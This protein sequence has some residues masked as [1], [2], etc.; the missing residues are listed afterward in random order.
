M[1]QAVFF[2]L[3]ILG[4][5]LI[6]KGSDWFINSVVWISTVFK[7]PHVIIG[8]TIVSVCTTL[9]ETLVSVTAALKGDT[10]FAFGNAIGSIAV[11]TDF[12][13]GLLILFVLPVIENKKNYTKNVLLLLGLL[14][15]ILLSG[16]IFGELNLYIGI[17]LAVVLVLYLFFNV[18]SARRSIKPGLRYELEDETDMEGEIPLYEGVAL[19]LKENEIDISRSVV[20]KYLFFFIIGI[21]MVILGSNLLVN[22]G[23]KI[24]VFLGVPS[25]LVATIF[26]SVGTSL[27]EL[28]TAISSIRK[29]ALGLGIGN[30]IGANVLNIIQ[31]LSFSAIIKP[32]ALDHNPK[33][34]YVQLP[35]V[36]LSVLIVLLYSYIR[37]AA[38]KRVF[39]IVLLCIYVIFV[40]LNII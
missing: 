23:I 25:I 16:V 28:V 7:I 17:L 22:N 13:M 20:A 32:I 21:S 8:A 2:I 35:I 24:A 5:V 31:V 26:T 38:L 14:A 3:F 18:K 1:E 6:I 34:L 40:L 33:I 4:L 9:P 37:K 10:D 12:I 11:N 15:F 19:D 30:I 27:P 36:I 39:G 29:K